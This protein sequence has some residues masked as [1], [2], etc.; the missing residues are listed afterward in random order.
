M[1][2]PMRRR[3]AGGEGSRPG[4]ELDVLLVDDAAQRALPDRFH[5]HQRARAVGAGGGATTASSPTSA[6]RRSRPPRSARSARDRRRRAAEARR[7][8]RL[9]RR[10]RASGVR[11]R[12]PH[13]RA[14]RTPAPSCSRRVGARR[15]R[16]GRR[17]AARGQGRRRDRP[18]RGAARAGRRG[19]AGNPRSRPRRPHRARRGDRAGARM[20]RLGAAGPEL[21]VDR[22]RGA[23]GALPHAE[24]RAREIRKNVLLTIDWG[25]LHEGY[26][27][28]CTRTYAT[29]ERIASGRARS[30]RWCS[31]PRNRRSPPSGRRR[32]AK[33]VDAVAR[34]RSSAAG[35]G[36][37]FG[38]GLGHG[39]GLEVHEGPRLSRLAG[40]DP[41]LVGNVVT[42]EPAS[43]CPVGSACGSR[44]S[45]SS[46]RTVRR[47]YSGSPRSSRSSH[48]ASASGRAG[49]GA[50]SASPSAQLPEAP[51]RCK[52]GL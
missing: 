6:T 28:D 7:R 20:R 1:S 12:E 49:A 37:H 52:R 14:A 41:L 5:R 22:R 42:V 15:L 31:R 36:D 35:E 11:R 40:E 27:S 2:A 47:C 19:A 46:R 23:H 17:A 34:D 21:P 44:T 18:H 25:A 8:A 51:R 9:G 33:S 16:G 10:R 38:H 50:A 39:V 30:T 4:A 3:A 29:G 32:T 43:T 24:P 26:C 13:R 45:S 48:S